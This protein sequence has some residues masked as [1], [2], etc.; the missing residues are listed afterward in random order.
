MERRQKMIYLDS[1]AATP[2]LPEAFLA[3]KP[4]LVTSFANPSALYSSAVRIRSAIEAARE[5]VARHLQTQP[6]T[7][8]FT[9]GGTESC[10][11]AILGTIRRAKRDGI[12]EPHVITTAI[13]HHAVL[14]SIAVAKQEGASVTFLPVNND[15]KIDVREL[16]AAV[17]RQT[18]LISIMYANNEIGTIEPMAD[19]GRA[20]IKIRKASSSVYPYFHTDACQAS[21]SLPLEVEKLHVDLL[22]MNA[23]KVYGPKGVGALF[24][25]RGVRIDPL[26]PGGGQEFGM[27]SGT[28]NTAGIIG[29]ATALHEIRGPKAK[30]MK[31][32]ET[33]RTYTEKELKR[34]FPDCVINGPSKEEDRLGH[35]LSV[36]FNGVDAEALIMYLDAKGIA[37]SSGSA[38]A[39]GS[40]E[41]SHV[42]RACGK[43]DK[44]I[45]STIRF[46]FGIYNTKQEIS[47]VLK[48]LQSLIPMLRRMQIIS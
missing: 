29:F 26:I 10:A 22:T 14:E 12:K 6:D 16:A 36:T 28:E 5:I 46:S 43:T 40:E 31:K 44:E 41:G 34:M 27:R 17:T 9:S 3:M 39:S 19:I 20:I 48:T 21:A 7:I 8:V 15:G 24:V 42:L 38:C 13:E 35:H 11:T 25:R 47:T 37:V 30:T 18:V 32:I 2:L 45:R 23:S 1:A 33:L 4:Y